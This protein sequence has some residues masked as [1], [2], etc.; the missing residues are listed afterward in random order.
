M[1]RAEAWDELQLVN[2]R[3]WKAKMRY[4]IRAQ[5]TAMKEMRRL[6]GTEQTPEGV[7]SDENILAVP[8][9]PAKLSVVISDVQLTI[10][11][12][13]FPLEEYADY[14]HKIGKGM[15]LDMKYALLIP[16]SVRLEMGEARV[17]LRDYPL[18]L[19]HIPPLRPGQPPNLPSWSLST[20]F[21]IAEEFRDI[22]SRRQVRVNVVPPTT[23][24]DGT[25]NPGFSVDVSRTICPIK[26]Y[27][28]PTFEINTN[29]PTSIS[30]GMSYQ[31]VIQDVM[32]IFEGFTK[33]EI[34]P[35]E[36]VGFWDKIRL[37]FHSRVSVVWKGDGDVHFKLKGMFFFS[38][39]YKYSLILCAR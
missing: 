1:S 14:I 30:W 6:A 4:S 37:N 29:L 15:P 23:A 22:E 32:K 39:I 11:K 5:N 2:S 35:S 17:H 27:S 26:T 8:D 33:P 7:E 3:S 19:L 28:N 31:P 13:S 16:M 21:V 24:P 18:D 20:D 34:D 25:T 36:V 9:R 10:D 12:P 38:F